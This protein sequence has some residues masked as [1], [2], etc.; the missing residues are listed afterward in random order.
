MNQISLVLLLE[1]NRFPTI[2]IFTRHLSHH[3]RHPVIV[4]PV[5]GDPLLRIPQVFTSSRSW[6]S[7]RPVHSVTVAE[8]EKTLPSPNPPPWSNNNIKIITRLIRRWKLIPSNPEATV[9]WR[10]KNVPFRWGNPASR[11]RCPVWRQQ[12]TTME[13]W[14]PAAVESRAAA[15]AEAA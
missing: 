8:V 1:S 15:A 12:L 13:K 10:R 14:R 6:K 9:L 2:L 5:I 11:R 3:L 7:R 4:C